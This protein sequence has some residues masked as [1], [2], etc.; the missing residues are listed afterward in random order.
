LA[1]ATSVVGIL[2]NAAGGYLVE[3]LPG[4]T[5][6]ER[7]VVE[8]NLAKLVALDGSDKIPTNL[9]LSGRTP[10]DIASMI[11]DGLD[12]VP[13]QQIEPVLKCQ[14][15]EDRLMRSLR[16]LPAT[17]VEE[18]LIKQERVEARCEFCGKVYRMEA[19]EVRQK[20]EQPPT[21]PTISEK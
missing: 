3:Q 9:L 11:L 18:I 5:D 7:R 21:D 17:D 10:L 19:H 13:L 15:T 12:M 2:C 20:L 8:A 1:A 6:D 4:T 14:C 16:L